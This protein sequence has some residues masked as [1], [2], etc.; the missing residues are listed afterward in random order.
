MKTISGRS[1]LKSTA[2]RLATVSW[3][4]R[5]LAQRSEPIPALVIGSGFG[6]AIAALRLAQAVIQTLVLERGIRWPITP[7]Q[8]TFATFEK[9]DGRAAWL[10]TKS[11]GIAPY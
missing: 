8:D 11:V 7:A 1:S 6:G 4:I 5:S 10:S 9:P 2:A 3:G